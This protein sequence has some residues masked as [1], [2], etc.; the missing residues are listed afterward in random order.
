MTNISFQQR[1]EAQAIIRDLQ[2]T[3]GLSL[4]EI[5][6]TVHIPQWYVTFA[7]NMSIRK[8]TDKVE[9]LCP[10]SG[11]RAILEWAQKHETS[12]QPT[13]KTNPAT[14]EDAAFYRKEI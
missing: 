6:N 9:Y 12:L 2:K 13:T 5:A 1:S 8:R 10:K 3:R 11:I 7:A 14:E 4:C